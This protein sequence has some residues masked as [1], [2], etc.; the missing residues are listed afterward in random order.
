MCKGSV[1][2]INLFMRKGSLKKKYFLEK[3]SGILTNFYS[4]LWVYITY[5][6]CEIKNLVR[7]TQFPGNIKRHVGQA[8]CICVGH[9]C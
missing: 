5:T 8:K 4:G 7:L 9:S 2:A 3:K 1:S 6:T